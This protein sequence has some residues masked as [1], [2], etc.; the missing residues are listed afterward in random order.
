MEENL[1]IDIIE[2]HCEEQLNDTELMAKKTIIAYI[3]AMEGDEA[4][5]KF[6]TE[7]EKEVNRLQD[8]FEILTFV[9]D[10]IVQQKIGESHD[11][12]SIFTAMMDSVFIMSIFEVVKTIIKRDKKQCITM[13]D[14][15]NYLIEAKS[16]VDDMR[17]LVLVERYQKNPGLYKVLET[18]SGVESIDDIL[19]NI[20]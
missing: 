3:V 14:Y 1:D 19:Y 17:T 6:N 12:Q 7:I 15:E 13:S 10:Y 9:F 18:A 5:S 8:D 20:H 2:Q 11:I 16:I 4:L